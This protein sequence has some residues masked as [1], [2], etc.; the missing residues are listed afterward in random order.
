[1][2]NYRNSRQRHL[3]SLLLAIVALVGGVFHPAFAG[4]QTAPSLGTAA[5]YALLSAAPGGLGA[6]TCT[7]A[8]IN[9]DVGSTGGPVS[10][11]QTSCT[12]TGAIVAPVPAAVVTDFNTAYSSITPIVCDATIVG[13]LAG[14]NLAPGVYCIDSSG[15]TGTLTLTGPSNGIWVF[16]STDGVGTGIL[17]G[18]NFSV[19]MAGGGQACN[20]YWW[21]EQGAA[22]TDSN[23]LGTILAG[24]G[25]ATTRGTFIGRALATAGV[26]V[27][28]PA[29]GPP[30][31]VN[32]CGALASPPDG[33]GDPGPQCNLII[34]GNAIGEVVAV[35]NP[36]NLEFLLREIG[37]G[38]ELFL[39]LQA[40]AMGIPVFSYLTMTGQWIPL[41]ADLSQ[42]T[43][44]RLAP[45]DGKY[46]LFAGT[47]PNGKYELYFGCDY[48]KN[49][50]L[51]YQLGAINGV[52]DHLIVT[53]Q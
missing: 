13:S 38:N 49:G 28:G 37:V 7:D 53:V 40:P 42:I 5:S 10:V 39:V 21:V 34:N 20:V 2:N 12:I 8:T 19:V 26:T 45:P 33:G 18:T 36:V 3:F 31:V 41:P 46:P 15:K 14:Q 9:G 52:F 32:G 1:M 47:V 25:V 17:A 23:F 27:T 24:A 43:P 6:V 29:G 51:D 16:K 30:T 48:V 4:H 22:M 44:F 50:H 11:T 35:G